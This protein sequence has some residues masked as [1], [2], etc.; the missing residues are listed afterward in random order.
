MC[1]MCPSSIFGCTKLAL[2]VLF[3]MGTVK[4]H[5]NYHKT[6]VVIVELGNTKMKIGLSKNKVHI[7]PSD[8]LLQ[9]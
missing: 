9:I 6:R 3:C 4:S 5:I 8:V 2:A 1:N 7:T